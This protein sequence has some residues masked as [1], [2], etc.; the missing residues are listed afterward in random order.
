MKTGYTIPLDESTLAKSVTATVLPKEKLDD[1]TFQMGGTHPAKAELGPVDPDATAGTAT[2]D[3]KGKGQST[4]TTVTKIEAVCGGN[5]V[6]SVIVKVVIPK[7]IAQ[8]YPEFG[9]AAPGV[10]D[11]LI[12]LPLSMPQSPV[13]FE[14]TVGA[15]A[16][17]KRG[18]AT[19]WHTLM[20]IQIND[21][22]GD[23]L[24]QVY[25]GTKVEERLEGPP[26]E[27]TWVNIN[28][29]ITAAGSYQ[30]PV[31]V[32]QV[33]LDDDGNPAY[34]FDAGSP[35]VDAWLSDPL[36]DMPLDPLNPQNFPVKVAGISVGTIKRQVI[37]TKVD[38]VE[39][40][41]IQWP[42]Q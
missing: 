25:E 16:D 31:G 12:G 27:M 10:V 34:I 36:P 42:P 7:K 4:P 40:I 15:L 17:N 32:F 13:W 41:E 14:K 24:D 2:F 21:Q 37:A 35:I 8:P 5:V 38:G 1:V 39:M 20:T 28:Q 18:L 22:F 33:R 23:P 19:T 11:N 6:G 9:P 3:V 29:N 30:D 26:G